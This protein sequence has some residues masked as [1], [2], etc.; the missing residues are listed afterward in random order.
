[1]YGRSQPP[2]TPEIPGV[3][4]DAGGGGGE[5]TGSKA[6]EAY[7]FDSSAL[8]R[9]AQAA[10]ELEK[11]SKCSQYIFIKSTVKIFLNYFITTKVI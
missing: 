3:P 1:M 4:A 11:S 6:M 10:R 9:A 2:Q 5:S 7:R 8:E